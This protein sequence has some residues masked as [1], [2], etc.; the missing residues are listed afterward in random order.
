MI[1]VAIPILT[2]VESLIHLLY[3]IGVTAVRLA[4]LEDGVAPSPGIWLE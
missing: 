3:S 2:E 4:R 1:S